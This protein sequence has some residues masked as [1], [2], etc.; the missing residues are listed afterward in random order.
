MN[1]YSYYALLRKLRNL[2]K[3]KLR[4][5]TNPESLNDSALMIRV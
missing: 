3:L 1:D 2:E 4:I 5:L